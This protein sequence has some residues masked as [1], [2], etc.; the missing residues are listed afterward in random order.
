[1]PINLNQSFIIPLWMGRLLGISP[2][3][4]SSVRQ[5]HLVFATP[6]AY[7]FAPALLIVSALWFSW[8]YYRDGTRPGW[9]IKSFLLLLRLLTIAALLIMLAQP[10]LRLGQV[11][12]IR[13]TALLLVDSSDSMARPDKKLPPAQASMEASA[14]GISTSD[15]RSLTRLE[16]LNRMLNHADIQKKIGVRYQLVINSFAS[17]TQA[18]TLLHKNKKGITEPIS[19]APQKPGGDST[20]I[21]SAL[22]VA[23]QTLAGQPVA[24]ILVASDGENNL[25]EDPITAAE[26]AHSLHIPVSSLGIGDPTKTKDIAL[27]NVLTDD[28]VRVHNVVTLYA[29]LEQRGYAGKTITVSLFRNGQPYLSQNVTLAPDDQKQEIKFTYVPDAAGRYIYTVRA[30]PQPGEITTANNSRSTVQIVIKKPLKVLMIENRPRWEF[31]YLKNAILRDTSIRFACLLLKGDDLHSGGDGNIKISGFPNDEKTLFDYDIIV[32]GDVPR[33]YFSDNQLELMRRFVEDRGGSLLVIAGEDH[34]P[35]EYAGSA[36]EPVLPM[37]FSSNADPIFTDQPFQWQ[38]TPEG[39]RSPIM[40]LDDDPARSAAIWQNLPGMFWCAG[41]E[42]ARPGATVLAVNP[43]RSNANG[44]YPVALYQSFGA[45][46]SY[47]DLADSTWRWRWRMGDRYFYRYWGQVIRFLTPRDLPGNA[48]FVQ[49]SVDRTGSSYR[50]GQLVTVTARILDPYY[51]PVKAPQLIAEEAGSGGLRQNILLQP[52]PGSPGLYS[53][54]IQ[55]NRVGKYTIT[56]ASPINPQARNSV[57]FVVESEA[58]E[59]Q[60]PELDIP[61]L[62]K[63]AAAGGGR[64]YNPDQLN[65]WIKSLQANP[66]V[67][68]S[69]QEIELWDA[70]LFLLLFITPL[71]LEWFLRKRNGL[72]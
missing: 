54:R 68:H 47:A 28:T 58:L 2:D 71:S 39:A 21:G 30:T 50:L 53:T 42:G 9:R 23:L 38:L 10:T 13:P 49:I 6:G 34:L 64:Y 15:A 17:H 8:L 41:T 44:P 52:V 55:P 48:R 29:D 56:A 32:L 65:K 3:A 35:Q 4:V 31:R 20:Q 37:I 40:M 67:I 11:Q 57:G 46:K 24:G 19:I 66:I 16:I 51:H 69:V 36:L 22:R 12:N 59:L 63:L 60:K 14:A 5:T 27:L 26:E 72:L 62:K 70:P 1:M 18:V 33:S 25:G 43:A 7:W 61:F 45:G